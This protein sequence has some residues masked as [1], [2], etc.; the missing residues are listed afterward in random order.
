MGLLCSLFGHVP[1]YG[2]GN[3]PGSG[4]FEV[5][6]GPIDGILRVHAYLFTQCERCGQKYQVGC[7]HVPHIHCNDFR[8]ADFEAWW[9]K[10]T[11]GLISAY[12]VS[13]TDIDWAK[14]LACSA[15]DTAM[16]SCAK[17]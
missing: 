12:G 16:N 13:Q 9:D 3:T 17:R 11:Y 10:R 14:D 6:L 1:G 4:Y 7:I 15:W 8:I 5:R 2:Y